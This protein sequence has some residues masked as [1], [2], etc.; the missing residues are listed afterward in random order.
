MKLET[1]HSLFLKQA[2]SFKKGFF[3]IFTG[4]ASQDIIAAG[5]PCPKELQKAEK[6]KIMRVVQKIISNI[7][8]KE[9]REKA[10]IVLT[11]ITDESKVI[12]F[13]IRTQQLKPH[14]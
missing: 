12:S 7:K 10:K 13:P 3:L 2:G 5:Y 8:S 11:R 1:K 14:L 6:R 4:S 9:K